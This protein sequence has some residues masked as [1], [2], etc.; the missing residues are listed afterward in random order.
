[1]ATH[2]LFSKVLVD[3]SLYKSCQQNGDHL[4]YWLGRGPVNLPNVEH[5][6][7]SVGK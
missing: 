7:N 6:V 3:K 2:F 4:Y 1:M 5:L